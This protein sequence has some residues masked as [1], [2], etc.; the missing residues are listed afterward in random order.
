[1]YSDK[2]EIYNLNYYK[3]IFYVSAHGQSDARQFVVPHGYNFI[4]LQDFG[5]KLESPIVKSIY[6]FFKREEI[7]P[8]LNYI[9]NW[10]TPEACR[11][12]DPE[13]RQLLLNEM[14]HTGIPFRFFPYRSTEEKN[15]LR[16]LKHY[17]PGSM[18]KNHHFNFTH[19][20]NPETLDQGGYFEENKDVMY[21]TAGILPIKEFD[22]V[23]GT[24]SFTNRDELDA[25][26]FRGSILPSDYFKSKNYK[27]SLIGLLDL[28]NNFRD[29]V[30]PPGTYFIMSCRSCIEMDTPEETIEWISGMRQM[31]NSMSKSWC[32]DIHPGKELSASSQ[33]YELHISGE[34]KVDDPYMDTLEGLR[35]LGDKITS[36]YDLAREGRSKEVMSKNI[37]SRKYYIEY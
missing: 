7:T 2:S 32:E 27:V 30:L 31:S 33:E 9:I 12:D 26:M 15:P 25:L 11:F 22:S 37:G 36:Q 35:E 8:Y 24:R 34:S 13:K 21:S 17:P 19:T 16:Y 5:F 14:N 3:N 6:N 1:M 10:S 28:D 18:M 29:K 4:Q 23:D 20:W